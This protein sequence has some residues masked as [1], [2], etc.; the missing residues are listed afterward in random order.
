[1]GL[2]WKG[3]IAPTEVPTGDGRMFAAGKL[4][5]RPLPIPLMAKFGSGGH[6]GAVAVGKVNRI[7][8]GPG[9]YWG[10]GEF[11]D[12]ALVPEV[13][14]AIYLLQEKVSGPSVDLDRDFTVEAIKHPVRPEKKAGLFKEYNVIGVTLV[15]MPAFHQVHMAVGSGEDRALL[16]SVMP[17]IDVDSWALFDVNTESW[18]NWPIAPRDYKFDAD[19]AVKRIA[20]WAGIGSE[21]PNLDAYASAFLWRRG[22]EAGD[23]LAQDS[24]RLPLADIINGEPYLIYHAAYSAAA[25]LSGAHGGLPNIPDYD[26][27]QMIPVLIDIY[28]KL[29]NEFGDPNLVSPFERDLRRQQAAIDSSF[30]AL[31]SE[32]ISNQSGDNDCGCADT[33]AADGGAMSVSAV[34]VDTGT[35][36]V[37]RLDGYHAPISN[38]II[39]FAPT[40][41]PDVV[42]S[43]REEKEA[44]GPDGCH[45]DEN[46]SCAVCGY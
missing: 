22:S 42:E 19:D 8:D 39:N 40:L 20:Y 41:P 11:L 15:P 12:P 27:E 35:G 28:A 17:E 1:M 6:D 33:S 34:P 30:D 21:Q 45:F 18:Q 31:V 2:H 26:K 38:V 43:M 3:L 36:S 7:F 5:H 29:A 14:K 32:I 44:Y 16:A 13:P 23:T 37:I 24:F 25:L 10:E 9:G 46:G 4:T